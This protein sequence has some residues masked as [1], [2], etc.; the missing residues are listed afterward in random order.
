[1]NHDN[2]TFLESVQEARIGELLKGAG[3]NTT[4]PVAST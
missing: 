1:M 3:D 2:A 4:K